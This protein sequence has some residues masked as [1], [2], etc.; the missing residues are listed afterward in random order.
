[1]PITQSSTLTTGEVSA[2]N[3]ETFL[4]DTRDMLPVGTVT[5]TVREP[6]T[7]SQVLASDGAGWSATLSELNALRVADKSTD[8][9]YGVVKVG[10]R[11]GVAGMGYVGAPA[12]LGWD[13]LP[14]GSSTM[15]HELG[16]NFGRQH[17]P[18]GG[19]S[20][21]DATYP[22][23]GGSIGQAGFN[24]RTS[25]LMPSSMNDL[26]GYCTPK[27][28]SD[29]NYSAMMNFRGFPTGA[30]GATVSSGI[31][32]DGVL[33]WGRVESDGRLVL[34]PSVRI[35]AP[36]VLPAQ[37]GEYHITGR[38]A[39]GATI[40]S[41]SF[42]PVAVS[43]ELPGARGAHF[44]FVLP[45]DSAAYA[46]LARVTVNGRGRSAERTSHAAAVQ[47]A[48]LPAP[49]VAAMSADR[50]RMKWNAAEFPMAVVRDATTGRILSFARGGDAAF[51]SRRGDVEV[52]LTDGV[53]SVSNRMRVRGAVVRR[54]WRRRARRHSF[55]AW[56]PTRISPTTSASRRACR[57]P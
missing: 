32:T 51:A 57:T 36:S 44:A 41:T 45:I 18:C 42:T 49:D 17:A 1:M 6:Y 28:I 27:W 2:T 55:P 26:M 35:T 30:D 33:V 20:S 46:R 8:H 21:S 47:A 11:S 54:R 50:V 16:H 52:I 10:Y 34:E 24:M 13:L 9:Y 12:S 5:Y 7:T 40:F 3:A 56:P 23:A 43:E 14:S 37:S 22:Y 29:Y 4:R 53:R 39:A 38:D 19:V 48:T 15:A 31:A 25:V